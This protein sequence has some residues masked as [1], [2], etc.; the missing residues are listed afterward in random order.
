VITDRARELRRLL[1]R[2]RG[3]DT[4]RALTIYLP[5]RREGYDERYYSAL[6]QDLVKR[7]RGR[8]SEGER[9]VIGREL[10]RIQ[11]RLES[12]HPGGCDGLAAFAC[13][14]AGVLALIRLPE[15]PEA[16]LEVGP[17][18]LAP[19]DR[20]LE[21]H[22][23]TLVAVVDKENA[24]IFA[25]ILGELLPV[26]EIAGEQVKHSRAGG[27][28]A[29]SNQRKAENRASHNLERVAAAVE[30]EAEGFYRELLVAGPPEART[31]FIRVLPPHLRA[32][33]REIIGASIDEP[34]GETLSELRQRLAAVAQH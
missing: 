31:E 33:H 17:P 6:L 19:I 30:R 20:L 23:P 8:L 9:E 24:R 29:P 21:T 25:S 16:R 28:S 4:E 5:L 22:P 15:V 11:R 32:L 12:D 1:E 2:V 14:A 34:F 27:S 18:L 26:A 7:Y 10:P 13:E 3:L